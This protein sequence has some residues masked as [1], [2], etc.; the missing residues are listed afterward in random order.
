[1]FPSLCSGTVS[2]WVITEFLYQCK[3]HCIGV[4]ICIQV[5]IYFLCATFK[6]GLSVSVDV[7]RL[8][9]GNVLQA[10]QALHKANVVHKNLRH[11]SIYLDNCGEIRLGDYS[12]ESRI[13]EIF[14]LQGKWFI[15]SAINCFNYVFLISWH[16]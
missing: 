14:S 11:S 8:I 10:L 5:N 12:L 16:R 6:R 9:T 7:I 4:S 1:M 3:Y 2:A 15:R 13:N